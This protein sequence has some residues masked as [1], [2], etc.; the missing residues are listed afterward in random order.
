MPEQPGSSQVPTGFL[1]G[2]IP[3][4]PPADALAGI[5]AANPRTTAERAYL[6]IRRA[7]ESHPDAFKSK[8]IHEL[9][10]LWH[11]QV[12]D[13]LPGTPNTMFSPAYTSFMSWQ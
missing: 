6:L 3:T 12:W 2:E 9:R 8:D 11:L 10:T 5:Q 1:S 7:Q 4:I 13:H